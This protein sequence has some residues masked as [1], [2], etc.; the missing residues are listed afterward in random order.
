MPKTLLQYRQQAAIALYPLIA[1]LVQGDEPQGWSM[2]LEVI[3]GYGP[4]T[5]NEVQLA[6]QIAAFRLASVACAESAMVQNAPLNTLLKLSDASV[7][8]AEHAFKLTDELAN[9]QRVRQR[10]PQVLTADSIA[11]GP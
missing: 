5:P 8:L 1:T 9:R 2:I 4:K 11:W 10:A 7:R 3:D 6:A